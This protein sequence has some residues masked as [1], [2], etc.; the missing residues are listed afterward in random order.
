MRAMFNATL[1][2]RAA[3]VAPVRIG[4]HTFGLLGLVWSEPRDG[5]KDHEVALVEGIA[6]Q[7]GTALERDHLSAE[8]MR[9]KSALHERY[10]EEGIIGQAPTIRRAIQLGLSVADMQTSVLLQGESG[11][12]KALM[13]TIIHITSGRADAQCYKVT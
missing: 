10:G 3:L 11:T 5:F 1:G 8:V 4:S 12:G 6:D 7:I 13:A 2:G 9:L